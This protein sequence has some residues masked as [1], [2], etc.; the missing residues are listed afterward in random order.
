[1]LEERDKDV[2]RCSALSDPSRSLKHIIPLPVAARLR[3][4]GQCRRKSLWSERN[5]GQAF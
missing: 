3:A 4:G 5:D 2:T 1:M